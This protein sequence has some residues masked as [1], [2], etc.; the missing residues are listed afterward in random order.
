MNTADCLQII[1]LYDQA[2]VHSS[3][4]QAFFALCG[5]KSSVAKRNRHI[6]LRQDLLKSIW[7]IISLHDLASM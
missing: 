3:L 1:Q 5:L 4:P 2:L 7:Q 6:G